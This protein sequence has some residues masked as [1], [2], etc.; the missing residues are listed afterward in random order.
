VDVSERASVT[1]LIAY[2]VDRFGRESVGVMF[3]NAG[4]AQAVPLLD[5]TPAQWERL[6]RI[7]GLGVVHTDFQGN[8]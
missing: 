1:A 4:V 6:M 8:A 2:T 5:T 3:N 7:N